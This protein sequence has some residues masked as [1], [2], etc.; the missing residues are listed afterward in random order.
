MPHFVAV[1]AKMRV[2]VEE[3]SNNEIE[4]EYYNDYLWQSYIIDSYL[5]FRDHSGRVVTLLPP[6]S[7]IGVQNPAQTLTNCMYW[8]LLPI[9]LPVEI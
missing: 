9:K 1:L 5:F 2:L 3:L 6:T 4:Q 7:E 8:F